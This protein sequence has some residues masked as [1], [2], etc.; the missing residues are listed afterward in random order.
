MD[1]V[2]LC[3]GLEHDALGLDV[4]YGESFTEV[5]EKGGCGTLV[6]YI[7]KS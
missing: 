7:G 5:L 4:G 6:S 1:T 3:A 2:V